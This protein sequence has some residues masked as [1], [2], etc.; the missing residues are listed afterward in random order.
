M[1][2]EFYSRS[3]PKYQVFSEKSN[4]LMNESKDCV[5]LALIGEQSPIIP[6]YSEEG[7]GKGDNCMR[8]FFKKS[9]AYGMICIIEHSCI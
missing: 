1:F 4:E 9:Q 3:E 5:V 2:P 8:L 6:N 7:Q